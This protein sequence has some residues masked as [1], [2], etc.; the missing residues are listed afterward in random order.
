MLRKFRRIGRATTA[1]RLAAVVLALQLAAAGCAT[2]V[3]QEAVPP[4]ASVNVLPGSEHVRF[5]V[6]R[7]TDDFAD[8]ARRSLAKERAW[9]ASQGRQGETPRVNLLAISG[10]GDSGA[11]GAGLLKGWSQSG[12]RPEFR[13]V[14]GISTGALI[15]PF[16]FLGS[17][18]DH[19]LEQFYTQTPADE[20]IRPR[21]IIAAF[22]GDALADTTP[23]YKTVSRFVDQPLLDQIAAEYAKGRVLLIGTTNLDTLEPVIWNMTAIAASKDPQAL[24][25]FR[26]VMLA[27]ASIPGAFPPVMIDQTVDGV[28]YQEMHVDGGTITQVFLYPPSLNV[29]EMSAAEGV[30][31]RERKLYIIRNARLDSDWMSV[32]RRTL[33]IAGRAI[34]SLMQTQGVGDLYRIFATTQRDGIDYNL[35]FIPATFTVPHKRDFDPDFM[36]PLF[37]TG[38]SMA[39]KGFPWQKYPPGWAST[40]IML[41]PPN[42]AAAT[43]PQSAASPSH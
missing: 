6:F 32:Q 27:S 28:H 18:Y 20:I 17:R 43:T 5:L 9:L 16:A 40:P 42:A 7:G 12:T 24:Q 34:L 26:R 19:L 31:E 33:P 36:R 35:A 13:V 41:R 8:E 3:R 38:E 10:G 23:L 22:F 29:A 15:A 14:T 2:P 30:A 25:L 11:F 1:P 37:A 21:N 4:T 39:A